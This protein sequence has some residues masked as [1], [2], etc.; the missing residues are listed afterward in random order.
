ML[1]L[2][3]F[4]APATCDWPRTASPDPGALTPQRPWRAA[5]ESSHRPKLS[6]SFL[7]AVPAHRARVLGTHGQCT[8]QPQIPCRSQVPSYSGSRPD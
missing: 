3:H 7:H 1:A 6:T 8:L 5:G 4:A 2:H